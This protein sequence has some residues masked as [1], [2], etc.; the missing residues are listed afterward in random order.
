[1]SYFILF[2]NE[3]WGCTPLLRAVRSGHAD[4]ARFL[5]KS[6]SDVY[7]QNNV[8][9]VQQVSVLLQEYVLVYCSC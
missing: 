5:L 3:Q 2:L 9:L 1:M 7:E 6:G 4:V 8:S